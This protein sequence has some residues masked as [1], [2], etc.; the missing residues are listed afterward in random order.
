MRKEYKIMKKFAVIGKDVSQSVSPEIHSFIADKMGNAIS[1]EK[2]SI[3]PED[4]ESRI[5]GLI[6]TYDGMN[7]TIPYKLSV[8]P[9]LE[10]I[11]DDAAIFGAVNTIACATRKG[12]NTD[13][14]GFTLMLK[15]NGVEVKGKTA[16]LLGAGGAGRS[17]AKKLLDGGAQVSVYDKMTENAKALEKEFGVRAL[18]EIQLKKYDIIVNATGVGMHR[19]VGVSPVGEELISLCNTAVDLIYVPSKSKFLEI[20]EGLGKKIINGS[21]ML[22]YQAYYSQCY[23]FGITPD[24]SQA[25]ELFESYLKECVK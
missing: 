20:A 19:T 13:G 3:N 15:N 11:Y 4:F 7:V 18:S 14:M 22:F 2:I 8:I 12:Y 1:Y 21:A 16:L 23:Y 9:H 24:D 5:D 6:A 25:K 10:G 17:V